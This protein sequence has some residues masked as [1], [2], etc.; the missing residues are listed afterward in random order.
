MIPTDDDA[1]YQ[2]DAYLFAQKNLGSINQPV[3]I[4]IRQ[5]ESPLCIQLSSE[6]MTRS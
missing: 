6:I 5:T 3:R 4:E 1:D 2:K